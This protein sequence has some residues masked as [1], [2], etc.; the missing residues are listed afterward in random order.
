MKVLDSEKILGKIPGCEGKGLKKCRALVET[1]KVGMFGHSLG[2][3]T[4]GDMAS[5]SEFQKAL[6]G[7]VN[8]DGLFL[9]RTA[10]KGLK[11]PFLLMQA[12]R[13]AV[14]PWWPAVKEKARNASIPFGEVEQEGTQHGSFTD[15][16]AIVIQ[17]GLD[18]LMPKEMLDTLIGGGEAGRQNEVLRMYLGAF[19]KWLFGREENQKRQP[20]GLLAGDSPKFPEM[21]WKEKHW[22]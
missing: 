8:M 9:A 5:G 3:A 13:D 18:N 6:S 4:L 20:L 15:L 14:E 16:P 1:K 19:F 7:V 17:T 22:N 11:V 2:G 10:A 21:K 12:D